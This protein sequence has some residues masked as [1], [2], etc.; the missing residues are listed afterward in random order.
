MDMDK[1]IRE[2]LPRMIEDIRSLVAIRSVK[3]EPKEDHPFGEKFPQRWKRRLKS[4]D[5]WVS[6]AP[7]W[8]IM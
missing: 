7:I 5:G 3:G 6:A 2:E 1:R 4:A 8:T